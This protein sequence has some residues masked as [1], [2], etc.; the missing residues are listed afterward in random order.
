MSYNQIPYPR[1]P[2]T[3]ERGEVDSLHCNKIYV[4]G[5]VALDY[6]MPTEAIRMRAR[7]ISAQRDLNAVE[8]WKSEQ[9]C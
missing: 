4:I 2:T 6:V 3:V 9:H 5:E 7:I 1:Y 8:V